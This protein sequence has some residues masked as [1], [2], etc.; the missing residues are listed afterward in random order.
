MELPWASG[1]NSNDLLV[2]VVSLVYN[3]LSH[4]AAFAPDRHP[5]PACPS[6]ASAAVDSGV[7]TMTMVYW[8]IYRN[9]APLETAI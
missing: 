1:V 7:P 6:G 5:G 3:P 8:G 9:R 2:S 4:E